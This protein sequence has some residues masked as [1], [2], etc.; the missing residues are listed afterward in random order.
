MHSTHAE[1]TR[2]DLRHAPSRM[3]VPL[4]PMVSG[5]PVVYIGTRSRPGSATSVVLLSPQRLVTC[6]FDECK[7]Y[8]MGFDWQTGRSWL[9]DQC[10]TMADGVPCETDLLASD[11]QGRL[12]ATNLY[13]QNCSLYRVEGD[14]I[15][16]ERD[17]PMRCGADVHGVKFYTPGIVAMTSRYLSGGIHF[18]DIEDGR[19][20]FYLVQRDIAT[21]DVCFLSPGRAIAVST[22]SSP[23][24]TPV[25]I[26]NGIVDLIDLDADLGAA[27]IV[28]RRLLPDS[29]LDNVVTSGGRAYVTDQYNNTVLVLDTETLETV[30]VIR[31]YDFPHGVDAAHGLLAVSNYGNNTIDLRTL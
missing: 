17:V 24:M 20:L 15:R 9:I 19:R 8:L 27:R 7:M 14:S 23:S 18:A 29:H 28:R 2:T 1:A 6:Q 16:Y 11:G 26:H 25:P 3:V 21:Q 12:V 13:H 22:T 4:P 5:K 31:G 30:D 10:T